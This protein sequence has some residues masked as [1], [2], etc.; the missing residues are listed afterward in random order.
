L[1][2]RKKLLASTVG[3]F[4]CNQCH[5]FRAASRLRFIE[6]QLASPVDQPPEGKHWIHEIKHDA[7]SVIGT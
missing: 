7:T 1:E 6:L 2:E 5:M 3:G 4:F